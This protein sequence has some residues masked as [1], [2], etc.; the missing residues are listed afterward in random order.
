MMMPANFSAVAENELTYVVGGA[1]LADYLAPAMKAENWQKFNKNLIMIVGN[2]YLN[3]GLGAVLT[4][5]FSGNY[6]V[7]SLTKG[8]ANGIEDMWNAHIDA[9]K[10]GAGWGLLN[11]IANVGLQ[12]VG[13]LSAIYALGNG[14]VGLTLNDNTVGKNGA[15]FTPSKG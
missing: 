5:I 3:M 1:S 13:N 2:G 7:G 15:W 9:G 10:A 4:G 8:Y 12:V 11:A 14:D 6:R